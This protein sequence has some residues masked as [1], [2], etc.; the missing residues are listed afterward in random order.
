MLD[1]SPQHI[2][3]DVRL[4]V[5]L[6][7]TNALH[8]IAAIL[9]LLV[10]SWVAGKVQFLLIRSLNKTPHFDEML[11]RFFGNIARYF[12]LTL[13]LL[14]VLAQFGIQTTSLIAVIGAASLAIGLALQ[15]TLSHL[16][17]GVML[18]IFRPFRL[19]QHVQVGGTDGTVKELSLF[20]TE[21]VTGDNVQ[22]I[23][24][25]GSV[26]GQQLRN[27]STY[28]QPITTAQVRFRLP[29]ADPATTRQTIEATVKATPNVLADPAPSVLLD[30]NA[31]DN[32]LEFV[33]TF[34]PAGGGGKAGAVRSEI[35][36]A[37]HDALG[38]PPAGQPPIQ[39]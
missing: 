2:L 17:A 25:N 1:P 30:H 29:N 8:V 11:K 37:V 18:L 3:L 6:I 27:Y 35:I 23:I 32:A 36:Q 38:T 16:A 4:L 10:G 7:V 19:G 21:L 13:V 31:T 15:G 22:V 9:L 12:V 26:W 5:P 20:W 14:A 33:V 28:D 39:S 24:P 34:A